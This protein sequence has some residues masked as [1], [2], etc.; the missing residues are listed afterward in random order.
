M[1]LVVHHQGTHTLPSLLRK[2]GQ[3]AC[4]RVKTRLC[5]VMWHVYL[6]RTWLAI[7][8]SNC[9]CPLADILKSWRRHVLCMF[10]F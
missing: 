8:T 9:M 5:M 1:L 3:N 10:A 2:R 6:M 7:Q 4:Q